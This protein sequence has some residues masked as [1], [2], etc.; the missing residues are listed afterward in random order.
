MTGSTSTGGFHPGASDLDLV[1][2]VDAPLDGDGLGELQAVLLDL[3]RPPTAGGLDLEL[4]T[5]AGLRRPDRDLGWHAWIRWYRSSEPRLQSGSELRSSDW[6]P[7]LALARRCAIP[8]MGPGPREVF[9][10]IPRALV[11]AASLRELPGWEHPEPHWSIPGGVLTACRAWWCWAEAGL[12][13]KID[14][15]RWALP[16]AEDPEPIRWAL[17]H[18]LTGES[19]G[20]T[21]QAAVQFIAR[22]RSL[23]SGR[24]PVLDRVVQHDVV[25][26][27]GDIVL[28]PLTENDWAVLERWNQDP[29][30]LWYAESDDA[31]SN[32][33]ERV[34]QVARHVSQDAYY[35]VIEH[36][37]RPIGEAWL[38][39]MNLA[40]VLDRHRGLDCRRIDLVIGEKELWG[41]GIGTRV[42][43]AITDFGFE[44]ERAD[45]IFGCDIGDRNPRSLGAFGRAGYEVN[46][47]RR[48]D[49][50]KDVRESYD[51]VRFRR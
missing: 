44:T 51:V 37:G 13:S 3:G 14:A 26:H 29:E 15:G 33:P 41:T 43:R 32:A 16:R 2:V 40:R 1:M 38:Q 47:V 27:D 50:P 24:S 28:R 12:G 25:L 5:R 39:L 49:S 11:R 34:R 30:V 31:G 46:L 20:L 18:Y 48:S 9:G 35:F 36:E 23:T 4:F 10:P 21:A 6:A 45:A 17:Q 22:T 42:I 7:G 8:L 19:A